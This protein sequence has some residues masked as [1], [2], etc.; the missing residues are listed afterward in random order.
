MFLDE[1]KIN[2]KAGDGGSGIVSFFLL[3]GSY[4]KI[5]NGGNGGSGQSASKPSAP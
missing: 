4:K 3:K 5:A 1:A 2:I